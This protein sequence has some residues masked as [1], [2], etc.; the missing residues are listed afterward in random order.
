MSTRLREAPPER[1]GALPPA[2]AGPEP[3]GGGRGG[4]GGGAGAERGSGRTMSFF[5]HIE[6]LRRHLF[7]AALAWAVTTGLALIFA[8]QILKFLLDPYCAS[9]PADKQ[10]R[11]IALEPT[12]AIA[13]YFRVALLAGALVAMPVIV[14]QL[15]SFVSPGLHPR[16]R[17]YVYVLVPGASLLFA[18]G[19]AFAWLIF[20]P[21]AIGFLSTFQSTIFETD[22][23]SNEYIPFVTAML[24]WI[25]VA[26]EMPLVFLVLAR[27]GLVTW[28]QL[29]ANWRYAVVGVAVGAAVITPTPDP[30]N[31]LLVMLP[32]LGL[33]LFS[34][35]LAFLGGRRAPAGASA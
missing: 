8:E 23:R 26:F 19:V 30:F 22:W 12:E 35:L 25:G 6:E 2:G 13:T 1:A 16:E 34:I 21:A 17:R 11:L 24:F 31:M 29:I 33:Y 7:W 15:W 3:P 9:V 10:C 32:L 14:Y 5:D 4:R 20:L 27:L 28:R 18:L